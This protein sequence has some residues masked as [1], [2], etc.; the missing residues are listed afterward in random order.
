MQLSNAT[1][2][3]IRI[4]NYININQDGTLYS[5]RVLAEKLEIDYKFLTSIMTKLVKADIVRSIRGRGGGFELI[6]DPSTIFIID[7]IS[8]FDESFDKKACILGKDLCD[9]SEKCSMHDQWI[10]SKRTMYKVFED[11]TLEDL[12]NKGDRL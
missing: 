8:L 6:K 1:Q 2:Y 5:A 3:V 7:I 9:E 4:L 10:E 11:T 12:K